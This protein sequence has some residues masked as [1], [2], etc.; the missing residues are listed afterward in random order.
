MRIKIISTGDELLK[1]A[2]SDTN[3]AWMASRLVAMGASVERIE[4]VKDCV[5]E[6][7]DALTRAGIGSDL[8]LVGGGLGPTEDDLTAAAA[9]RAFGMPLVRFPEGERQIRAAFDR[10][11]VEMHPI[12]LKQ[13][14]LPEGAVLLEND[15]GTAPGFALT[16]DGVRYLF[17]PGVPRELEAMFDRYVPGE[18][19]GGLERP[20]ERVFRCFGS[21]ESAL[22]AKIADITGRWEGT[23]LSFRAS[24]PEIGITLRAPDRETLEGASRDVEAAI[25]YAVFAREPIGLPEALG[26]ALAGRGMTVGT[27]ESCTGGL[28]AHSIT[29]VPGSSAYFKGGIVC[30]DNEVKIEAAGVDRFLIEAHGAVSEE[31]ASAMARGARERLGVDIAMATSGI[32]GPGGGTDDKPVGLVHIAV[33]HPGGTA[34]RRRLF[35]GYSRDRVKTASAWAAMRMAL[36]AVLEK[37]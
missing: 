25:G 27:A 22:Q 34:H 11:G 12:N 6:I 23:R 37:K 21:G 18:L 29:Q 35:E 13:A 7:G 32:A 20:P 14:V 26:K 28:I 9:A 16:A 33:A 36:D 31:V 1:G 17:F 30:Y 15:R 10:I 8:V 24:F 5:E 4:V 2:I 19:P 3:G